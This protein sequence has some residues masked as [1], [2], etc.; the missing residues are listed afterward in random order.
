MAVTLEIPAT[1]SLDGLRDRAKVL[2]EAITDPTVLWAITTILER[3]AAVPADS[4]DS[5]TPAAHAAIEEGMQQAQ[6][7]QTVAAAE[8][9]APYGITF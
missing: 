9:F 3:Q 6:A 2:I 8:V 5:L 4:V 1:S 7:G